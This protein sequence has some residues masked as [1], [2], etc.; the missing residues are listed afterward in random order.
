MPVPG[1][2]INA[3]IQMLE[4]MQ[5]EAQ[6]NVAKMRLLMPDYMV[7]G[8]AMWFGMRAGAAAPLPAKEKKDEK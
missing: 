4:S 5:V 3:M 7:G 2:Q 8:G 1:L 6:A